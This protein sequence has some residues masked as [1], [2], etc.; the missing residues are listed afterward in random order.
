MGVVQKW[1]EIEKQQLVKLV[2]EHTKDSRTN[3]I[4][5]AQQM[6]RSPKQCK[7]Y[8]NTIIQQGASKKCNVQWTFQNLNQLL[9]CVQI[10]DKKW[11]LI[12]KLQ[13]PHLS[14]EQLRQKYN[15]FIQLKTKRLDL[16]KTLKQGNISPELLCQVQS[17]YEHYNNLK[18]QLDNCSDLDLLYKKALVTANDDLQLEELVKF[19]ASVLKTRGE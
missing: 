15:K 13:F 10:Y 2:N 19:L 1:S 17:L 7:S 4:T 16:I 6:N 8:Y 9:S 11:T 18:I 14:P 3:W 12:H 5:V